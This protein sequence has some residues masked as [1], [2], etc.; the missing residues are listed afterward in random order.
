MST[1]SIYKSRTGYLNYGAE[2]VFNFVTDIRNFERFMPGDSISEMK[3][4]KDHCS[5]RV[6]MLGEVSIN[7]SERIFPEKV[8][9]TGNARQIDDFSFIF[10]IRSSGEKKS[11]VSV[12][13]SAWMNP[14]LKM[15]ADE[16]IRQFLD[17][18]AEEIE[19]FNGWENTC[20][21]T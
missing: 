21:D 18:L 10:D 9:F 5:F 15:I 2:D 6:D 3:M 4:G 17:K 13:L 14:V 19:K 8:V 1:N 11:E 7:V 16:P 12:M 20:Q